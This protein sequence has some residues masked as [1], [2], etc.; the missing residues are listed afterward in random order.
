VST[1]AVSAA[2]P[3][4]IS[5]GYGGS[6][7]LAILTVNRPSLLNLSLTPLA[8][9]GGTPS[10][11]T[12]MLSGPAAAGGIMVTL[13]SNDP[14]V[15]SVPASVTVPAGAVSVTFTVTTYTVTESTSVRISAKYAGVTK[16]TALTVRRWLASVKV[17]P[18]KIRGGNS[19]TGTVMLFGQAP[20]GGAAVTLSSN[21]PAVASVPASVTVPANAVSATFAVST[22]AVSASKTAI[23]S[24]AYAGVTLTYKITI[25]P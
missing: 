6:S 2:T 17:N 15:A 22:S 11:G 12:V 19:A 5:A 9:A 18:S 25:N 10:T 14:A 24:A 7:R 1:V 23:I 16:R 8:V 21:N 20:E 3:V 13:S 4:T